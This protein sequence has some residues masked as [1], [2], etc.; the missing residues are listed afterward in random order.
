[1]LVADGAGIISWFWIK[2]QVKI[3]VVNTLQGSGIQSVETKTLSAGQAVYKFFPDPLS[4]SHS[5]VN[6]GEWIFHNRPT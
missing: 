2:F 3:L 4:F 1:M 6:L 5:S